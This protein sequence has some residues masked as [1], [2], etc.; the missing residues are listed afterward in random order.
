MIDLLSAGSPAV[1]WIEPGGKH[2]APLTAEVVEHARAVSGLA[3]AGDPAAA[4]AAHGQ[5]QVLCAH[6][7]G[8]MGVAGWNTR[9]ERG[10]GQ[11]ARESWYAGRPVM[12]RKNN[13]LLKLSNGDVGLAMP[14]G[15]RRFEAVFGQQE[16]FVRVPVSRLE[17]F[18]TVHALT[19]HKSQGSEYRHAIVVLPERSSRLLTRELLYTGLTRAVEKVTVVGKREVIEEAVS[20][21]VRRASGLADRL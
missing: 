9:V 4:L 20:R 7:E 19:I 16:S 1:Q 6:R 5:L 11:L 8:Q 15:G 2:L 18:E 13:P 12:V 21:P 3:E 14:A 10:L 17:E